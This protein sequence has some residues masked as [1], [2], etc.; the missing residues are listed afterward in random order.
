MMH[1]HFLD[2]KAKTAAPTGSVQA[3]SAIGDL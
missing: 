3:F 1:I 2:S